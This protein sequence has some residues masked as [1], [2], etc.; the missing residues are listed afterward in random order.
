MRV[1]FFDVIG[2]IIDRLGW[3]ANT[4]MYLGGSF[5][6]SRIMQAI[7]THRRVDTIM[8]LKV[9]MIRPVVKDGSDIVK[10]CLYVLLLQG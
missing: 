3:I 1:S 8:N 6:S 9:F 4:L 7:G 10:S 2:A 5:S